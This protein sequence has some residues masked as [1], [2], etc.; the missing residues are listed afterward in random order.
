VGDHGRDHLPAVHDGPAPPVPRKPG[1]RADRGD[2]VLYVVTAVVFAAAVAAVI[3][4]FLLHVF[5]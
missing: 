3:I 2:L 4:G 1:R 5:R